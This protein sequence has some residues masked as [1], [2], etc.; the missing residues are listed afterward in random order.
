MVDPT[1]QAS[2]KKALNLPK[3]DEG[4]A[5]VTVG[6]RKTVPAAVKNTAKV[7]EK[8]V[9]TSAPTKTSLSAPPTAPGKKSKHTKKVKIVRD[10]LTM[11]KSDYDKITALK[12]KCAENGVEVK[13]SEL[14]RAGLLILATATAEQ[15]L[16][17]VG[18]VETVKTGRPENT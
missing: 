1:T 18:A 2:K 15:L 4:K 12:L 16:A 11:P 8:T 13:K 3:A 17:A 14:L 5:P 10:S 9:E 7:R 6:R